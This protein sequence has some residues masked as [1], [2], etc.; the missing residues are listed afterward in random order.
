MMILCLPCWH[1]EPRTDR[2]R[3]RH[4]HSVKSAEPATVN[5]QFTQ[6]ETDHV[7]HPYV[8]KCRCL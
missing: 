4:R 2:V 3:N 8:Q 6:T 1:R 5:D 7:A